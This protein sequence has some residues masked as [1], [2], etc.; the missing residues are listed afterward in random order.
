MSL[1]FRS[2]MFYMFQK[3]IVFFCFVFAHIL[4]LFVQEQDKRWD[5]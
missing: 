4:Y 3:K 2:H 1:N 5:S